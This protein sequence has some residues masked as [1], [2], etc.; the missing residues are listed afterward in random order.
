MIAL[1]LAMTNP[2]QQ[3]AFSASLENVTLQTR[4]DVGKK[5]LDNVTCN[6]RPGT[7]TGLLGVSGSGKSTLHRMLAGRLVPT[8]GRV[9][10][11]NHSPFDSA[12][13]MPQTALAAG[14]LDQQVFMQAKSR[15]GHL[16]GIRPSWSHDIA[17][18]LLRQFNL[19]P[20]KWHLNL[21]L[22]QRSLLEFTFAM[23]SQCPL[24]LLDEVDLGVDVKKRSAIIDAVIEAYAE[25]QQTYIVSTH[26]ADEW[27][28]ALEDV[29]VLKSGQ[30]IYSG[31]VDNLMEIC[32]SH[33]KKLSDAVIW[34]GNHHG[35]DSSQTISRE[36]P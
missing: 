18:Q 28:S 21:S 23:A 14:G 6:F 22:G 35:A 8:S 13:T 15:L 36:K 16:A 7:V 2:L 12:Y 34:A 27:R 25:N 1:G 5:L 29:V 10:V 4:D 19:N 32:P 33:V 24:T 3:S 11:D 9:M 20:K 17:H 30:C 26:L 31:S